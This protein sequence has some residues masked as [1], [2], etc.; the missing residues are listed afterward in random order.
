[1]NK[2][3]R[4]LLLALLLPA[5]QSVLHAE[6]EKKPPSWSGTTQFGYTGTG[7][8]SQDNNL[9]GK[10]NLLYHKNKWNNTFQLEALFSN[11]AGG[12]TAERYA[13]TIELNYNFEPHSFGFYRNNSIYDRFNTYDVSLINAIGYG[14]RLYS[15]N[16]VTI[17]GQGGPGYRFAR[18]AGTSE[19]EQEIILYLGSTLKW[20]ISKTAHFQEAINIAAGRFNTMSK[21][22]SALT[23]DIIGNLGLQISFTITHNSNIPA[24]SNQ[25]LNTDYRTDVTL[26]FSF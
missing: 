7:G 5:Y 25:T 8:N 1:M 18:V 26:L 13:D 14:H 4:F 2:V 12:T 15:G 6:P 24:N 19:K 20:Q 11:N 23:T 10:F 21:S 16:K 17:D 3:Y 9:T 22:E